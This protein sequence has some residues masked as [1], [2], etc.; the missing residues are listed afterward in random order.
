MFDAQ[1]EQNA[2]D[3][4][5]AA[6]A[7][8]LG[9]RDDH[10][11]RSTVEVHRLEGRTP[12][13]VVTVEST[14][15]SDGTVVLYG[16]LDK[17]PPLGRLV[18]GSGTIYTRAPR[19]IGSTRAASPTTATRSSRRCSPSNR[20]KRTAF[21][22]RDASYSSRRARRAVAPT[23]SP[24]STTYATTSVTWNSSCAWTRVRSP[25]TVCG[26]PRHC[27]GSSSPRCA[28]AVLEQGQHSGSASGV[29]PSSFRILRELLDRVEDSTT[30]DMLFERVPRGHTRRARR[31]AATNSR[32]SSVTSS[33]ARF[34]R[35]P[36][37]RS[38]ATPPADR[39]LRRTWYPTLSVT[40]MGGSPRPRVAGNVLR[41]FT[42]AVL[43][44]RL[45]PNVER[46]ARARALEEVL[47]T[48]VPSRAKV[49]R[50]DRRRQ[51]LGR[52]APR[53]LARRRA[54][55]GVDR[56]PSAADRASPA[57]VARSRSSRR[58]PRAIPGCSSSPPACSAPTRTRTAIDEMLDLPMAVGVTNAVA[59]VVGA[60]ARR[61][62]ERCPNTL[63]SGS[64]PPVPGPG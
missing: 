63:I 53:P 47:T 56:T 64:T 6:I 8:A 48:D 45:P 32:T 12:M 43:S 10:S 60:H 4:R 62:D 28:S 19:A 49:E 50:E 46:H 18:R 23:S 16:H 40:G 57:K 26:S 31:P 11:P 52:A 21:P 17:Q 27:V 3:R 7:R 14:A 61:E 39:I 13:L 58:S 44:F 38:W 54:R 5:G 15:A 33:R 30:G 59:T 36:A 25:T 34:P 55:R 2:Q 35:C 9:A 22:T 41:P 42:T 51:R 1:W 29:V 24:T 37:S 20:S